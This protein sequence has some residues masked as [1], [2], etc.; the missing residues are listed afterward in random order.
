MSVQNKTR[1]QGGE[2]HQESSRLLLQDRHG[3]VHL[4]DL[5][6][7]DRARQY[8][9]RCANREA[10]SEDHQGVGRERLG[11]FPGVP[12]RQSYDMQPVLDQASQ[13]IRSGG[14]WKPAVTL[15][16]KF[17]E[18]L[19]RW[20]SLAHLRRMAAFRRVAPAMSSMI[21][22]SSQGRRSAETRVPFSPKRRV[23]PFVTT[24]QIYPFAG[25]F[26][27]CYLPV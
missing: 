15:Y 20:S 16:R 11:E 27:F 8:A 9:T 6:C 4:S 23:P 18:K 5:H 21:D 14:S 7:P 17:L 2:A 26:S 13:I 19:S 1:K 3:T 10:K 24:A 22:Y 25:I 12:E